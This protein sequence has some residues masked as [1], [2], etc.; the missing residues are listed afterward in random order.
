MLDTPE[1]LEQIF[2][3]CSM[4]A[5]I[6]WFIL[7]FLPR[8]ISFLNGLWRVLGYVPVIIVPVLLAIVYSAIVIPNMIAGGGE[9]GFDSLAGVRALFSNDTALLAGW[10]HYLAFDLLV[11]VMVAK[12]SDEE[13]LHRIIQVPLL[14]FTFMLGPF[15]YLLFQI[16]RSLNKALF[17]R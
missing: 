9:G 13:G 16:V 7:L 10:I 6:A 5:L 1:G 11:G 3:I 15:G 17:S 14:L 8:Q 2:S 4:L 12:K